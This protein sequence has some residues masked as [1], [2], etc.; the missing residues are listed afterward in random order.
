MTEIRATERFLNK[1]SVISSSK[2]RARLD[3]LLDLV[4]EVPTVGSTLNREQIRDEYGESCV[5]LDLSPF[6][7]VY[8]HDDDADTV[9]LYDII[10][11]RQVR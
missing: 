4:S 6:I 3:S 1:V 2:L 11:Q 9:S 10:H 5:T 7:I 8:E